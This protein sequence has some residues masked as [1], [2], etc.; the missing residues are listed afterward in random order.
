MRRKHRR[1]RRA[2]NKEKRKDQ[3]RRRKK[4]KTK[5]NGKKEREK[6]DIDGMQ[7]KEGIDREP[8]NENKQRHIFYRSEIHWLR[9]IKKERSKID[10]IYTKD[11]STPQ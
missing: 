5:D 8:D 9:Q 4:K 6:K 7:C 2:E 1:R 3:K 10:S 11:R